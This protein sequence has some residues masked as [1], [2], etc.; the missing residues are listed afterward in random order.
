MDISV[1]FGYLEI[2]GLTNFFNLIGGKVGLLL[3]NL[4]IQRFF[5]LVKLTTLVEPLTTKLKSA[6]IGDFDSK[7]DLFFSEFSNLLSISV[8]NLF[9]CQIL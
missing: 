9:K 5:F 1:S 7:K 4:E 3:N 6:P 8:R 2:K